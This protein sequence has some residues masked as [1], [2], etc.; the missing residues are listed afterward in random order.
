LVFFTSQFI[1][2]SLVGVYNPTSLTLTKHDYTDKQQ[3][4]HTTDGKPI[5]GFNLVSN[6]GTSP[7]N[8]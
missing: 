1:Q 3:V 2:N 5:A 4:D 6:G 8:I 7:K